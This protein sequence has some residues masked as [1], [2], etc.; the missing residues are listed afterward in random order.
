M[1]VWGGTVFI[2]APRKMFYDFHNLHYSQ[3][4]EPGVSIIT[5][6][7]AC[8]V[9]VSVERQSAILR[10]YYMS[11]SLFSV[12]QCRATMNQLQAYLLAFCRP[13]RKRS[14]EDCFAFEAMTFCDG[15]VTY[16]NPA[17]VFGL[18]LILQSLACF[19]QDRC[20]NATALQ[21]KGRLGRVDDD[22]TLSKCIIIMVQRYRKHLVTCSFKIDTF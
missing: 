22:I 12:C 11:S 7:R 2:Q 4:Y 20:W 1:G 21:L 5:W 8:S 16:T 3:G 19:S 15:N 6:A 10:Q 13:V 18:A 14:V 17:G 9:S